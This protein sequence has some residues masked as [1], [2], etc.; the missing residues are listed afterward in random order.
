MSCSL[1]PATLRHGDVVHIGA[2]CRV[3][4]N[5]PETGLIVVYDGASGPSFVNTRKMPLAI[6]RHA[7]QKEPTP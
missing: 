2:A 6:I 1:D 7:V 4:S 5:D 3:I